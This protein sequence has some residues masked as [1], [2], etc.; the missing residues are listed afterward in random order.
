[1]L[2]LRAL[3]AKTLAGLR[4]NTRQT[5][6]KSE[7]PPPFIEKVNFAE[8]SAWPLPTGNARE[9]RSVY[10]DKANEQDDPIINSFF[11][12]NGKKF[13]TQE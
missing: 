9:R 12:L 11:T 8:R 7:V 6:S 3:T 5:L 13:A 10:L 2:D 1:M 4:A